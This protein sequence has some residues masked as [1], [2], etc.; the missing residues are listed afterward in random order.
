MKD[1]QEKKTIEE[2]TAAEAVVELK[3]IFENIPNPFSGSINQVKANLIG[4][5]LLFK[6]ISE[7]VNKD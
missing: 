5:D 1:V 7:A 6:K 3:T 4:V 2:L